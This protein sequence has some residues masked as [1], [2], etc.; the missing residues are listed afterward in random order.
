MEVVVSPPPVSSSYP[1]TRFP[2]SPPGIHPIMYTPHPIVDSAIHNSQC[3]MQIK[4]EQEAV[5]YSNRNISI[6]RNFRCSRKE[7]YPSP[8]LV[9]NGSRVPQDYTLPA[10]L[11]T[12]QA[13]NMSPSEKKNGL[14]NGSGGGGNSDSYFIGKVLESSMENLMKF[15][16]VLYKCTLCTTLP[17]IL[18]SRDSFISH[19]NDL[20]LTKKQSH[21]ECQHCDLK[22]STEEDLRAHCRL[23]HGIEAHPGDEVEATEPSPIDEFTNK[24]EI[25]IST[26]NQC[27]VSDP[28]KSIQ[29]RTDRKSVV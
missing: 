29:N 16:E 28:T 15:A 12:D 8:R 26:E 19:V 27:T 4:T 22:F 13:F 6:N 3:H 21:K 7:S 1:L 2:E 20:H 5:N 23:S 17:S 11:G 25:E 10:K 18:T 9:T 14:M 24:S